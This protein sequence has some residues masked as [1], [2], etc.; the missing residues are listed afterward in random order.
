MIASP[1][2]R[3]GLLAAALLT[4]LTGCVSQPQMGAPKPETVAYR[5]A[6]GAEMAVTYSGRATG[7]E[8][9]ADLVWDG[10]S[11]PLKQDVSGS[12]ARY[13]DGTLALVTKGD[14]AFV[15]KAGEVVLKDCNARL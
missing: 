11:F 10:Q 5:C 2:V 14:E 7:L 9:S 13:T 6:D 8:G 1:L 3:P 15:E 12:G 4:T